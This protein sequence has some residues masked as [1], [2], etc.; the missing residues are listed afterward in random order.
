MLKKLPC[1]HVYGDGD[2]RGMLPA[3]QTQKTLNSYMFFFF[4]HLHLGKSSLLFF[5]TFQIA[6][7]AQ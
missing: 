7:Q 3:E 6:V 1:R 5:Q 2:K 4:L